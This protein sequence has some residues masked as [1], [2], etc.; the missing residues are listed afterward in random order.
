MRR[1]EHFF[2]DKSELSLVSTVDADYYWPL[3]A[4]SFFIAFLA[5]Y[6]AIHLLQKIPFEDAQKKQTSRLT[7]CSSMAMGAGIWS[8]HFT[9][10]LAY[11]LP[12]VHTYHIPLTLLSMAI[13][14][15]FSWI[16]F[17]NI[18]SKTLTLNKIILNA[19]I[20]GI[21]IASMHYIGMEAM[22]MDGQISYLPWLFFLSIGCGIIASAG[23][24]F[25]LRHI[26]LN[27][28]Y[29]PLLQ[30]A[31]ATVLALA[32]CSLHYVGM[33]AAVFIP[34]ADCRFDFNQSHFWTALSILGVSMLII[35]SSFFAMVQRIHK[36][37]PIPGSKSRWHYIYYILAIFNAATLIISLY[38]SHQLI[39]T[40]EEGVEETS[41]WHE[42]E[43]HMVNL[44]NLSEATQKEFFIASKNSTL[45]AHKTDSTHGNIEAENSDP[46][47][48]LHN[49]LNQFNLKLSSIKR[50]IE[51]FLVDVSPFN[52]IH[53]EARKLIETIDILKVL[54]VAFKDNMHHILAFD[55]A[56]GRIAALTEINEIL[57]IRKKHIS[58]ALGSI[59]NI[60]RALQKEKVAIANQ[61]KEQ[62]LF[63]LGLLAA[64]VLL[65]TFYG[66]YLSSRV[67]AEQDERE[68]YQN[69]L[70]NSRDNLEKLVE[71]QTK[72]IRA[73]S[74]KNTLLGKI[75]EHSNQSR[76]LETALKG[77]LREVVTFT[78]WRLGHFFVSLKGFKETI[79]VWY[80]KDEL[81]DF[82]TMIEK[83]ESTCKSIDANIV[84]G[85]P[86]HSNQ[87]T[88][89]EDMQAHKYFSRKEEARHLSLKG[90]AAVP[91]IL[92]GKCIGFAEFFS[93]E[94]I[95]PS[96]ETV[97]IMER[98]S[99]MMA[100][101]IEKF[102][103]QN[104]LKL[105]KEH[106]EQASKTKSEFL[107]NMSH[108]L[109]TPM[110][111]ILRFSEN[112]REE[113]GT[114]NDADLREYFEDIHKSGERLTK[115]INNLLDLS[116]LES[117]TPDMNY[118]KTSLTNL[119][120]HAL[121]E[122]Q[123]LID[124]KNLVIE[125]I[126]GSHGDM[127]ISLDADKITQVIINLMSNAIKF[128][129]DKSRI[130]IM[131][132]S[133]DDAEMTSELKYT[134]SDEGTGI[135]QD[136]IETIFDKFIQSTKTK[137]KAGG[138]G[139]GLSIC[140]EII[141]LHNGSIWA[142]NNPDKGTRFIFTIPINQIKGNKP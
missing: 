42:I 134:I 106:A 66:R 128:S 65:T 53:K 136:E 129:P 18:T 78:G 75:A 7:W 45:A 56:D 19:P 139:L 81:D 97:L 99:M 135:P 90:L 27:G 10:M 26:Y 116:K 38:I 44:D 70:Q 101:V 91:I 48:A 72:E 113:V 57:A 77:C 54:N 12:M 108:E 89:I 88:W 84:P 92:H 95:T 71:E 1:L 25:I 110:H 16:V 29:H 40:F 112:G 34:S 85:L 83:T 35:L 43:T 69:E 87:A 133:D 130:K 105:A 63:I 141:H 107:S 127:P 21:G 98:L 117:N 102:A 123:S 49:E 93:D 142:E 30:V 109:R 2:I 131:I 47:L 64:M 120:D 37:K 68:R 86:L 124:E 14:V 46:H 73:E 9:G 23:A 15:L 59:I 8:M 74:I 28:A 104:A 24:M 118:S 111:A 36:K 140:R 79:H 39:R 96:F 51:L 13:A 82:S 103:N 5:A 52:N 62:E 20:M 33:E 41:K 4:A 11:Q 6:S 137:T 125:T 80:S 76:T 94:K 50:E 138:T 119:N 67:L 115:L 114:S 32:V 122:L 22:E 58:T 3:V 61:F 132:E 31:A 126:Y 55:D 121:K 17:F 60:Q 100:R